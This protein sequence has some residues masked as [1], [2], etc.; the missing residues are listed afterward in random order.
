MSFPPEFGKLTE[1]EQKRLLLDATFR[2]WQIWLIVI[3]LASVGGLVGCY[4][5][6]P[7]N[8]AVIVIIIAAVTPI[9]GIVLNYFV[10]A[11]IKRALEEKKT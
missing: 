7:R 6:S 9:S 11:Y 3:V 2:Q 1:Q 10:A 8:G 4:L 5:P